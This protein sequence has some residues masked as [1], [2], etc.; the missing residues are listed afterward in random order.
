[1]VKSERNIFI[2]TSRLNSYV[3]LLLI[4]TQLRQSNVPY[5][6]K[7]KHL[8]LLQ[9]CGSSPVQPSWLSLHPVSQGTEG[10]PWA[11]RKGRK[12]SACPI[13]IF[14]MCSHLAVT[15]S[16]LCINSDSNGTLYLRIR[17]LVHFRSC[18]GKYTVTISW[19]WN[20]KNGFRLVASNSFK[21]LIL[22]APMLQ[23]V[24][25]TC[26]LAFWHAPGTSSKHL[27]KRL[28]LVLPQLK[29]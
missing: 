27:T 19:F 8:D 24:A 6:Q 17:F 12:Y 29:Q 10:H 16:W 21:A 26:S 28:A 11:S 25:T 9:Q 7:L 14:K 22:L 4:T 20:F 23:I 2:L 3:T 18:A 13:G 15:G 5:L 1:M